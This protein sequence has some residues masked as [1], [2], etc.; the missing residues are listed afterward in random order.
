MIEGAAA[1]GP[2]PVYDPE[3]L[4]M[5]REVGGPELAR[6]MID[7]F[8]ANAPQRLEAA[9]QALEAGD[10]AQLHQAAHSLKATS[11]TLGAL[12]VQEL[13]A[14]LEAAAREER[15]DAAPTLVTALRPALDALLERLREARPLRILLVD[16]DAEIVHLTGFALRRVGWEMVAIT[17]AQDV[18]AAAQQGPFDLILLDLFLGDGNGV[19]LLVVLRSHPRLRAAPV[20]LFTAETSAERLNPALAQGAAGH[21]QKPFDLRAL[22]DEVRRVLEA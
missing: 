19:D 2:A 14:E 11:A 22:P 15:L 6:E 18:E 5:L 9:E 7:L 10:A 17:S 3:A 12:R 13:S 4:G 8:L 1:D 20:A 21:I 16:D